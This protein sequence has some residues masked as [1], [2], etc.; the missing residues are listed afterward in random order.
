MYRRLQARG[1]PVI[2][3]G[4]QRMNGFSESGMRMMLCNAGH[5]L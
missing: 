4:K 2:L 5:R 3:P 1:V